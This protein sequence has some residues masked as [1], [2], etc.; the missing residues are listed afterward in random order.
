MI[1]C[2]YDICVL[3]R[4]RL[5]VL[6]H[7]M[8]QQKHD[9]ED[10]SPAGRVHAPLNTM[11][12]SVSGIAIER[13][14]REKPIIGSRIG[15]TRCLRSCAMPVWVLNHDLIQASIQFNNQVT[16]TCPFLLT[17]ARR[18]LLTPKA[19]LFSNPNRITAGP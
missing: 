15:C 1:F 10:A 4:I 11:T 5:Q 2:N 3:Q 8:C 7:A 17:L 6:L 9:N 19:S 14:K 13:K 12:T 16:Y 18:Q